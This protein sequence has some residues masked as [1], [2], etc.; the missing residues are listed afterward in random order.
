MP[1]MT[2]KILKSVDLT[3]TQNLDL[4]NKTLFFLHIKKIHSLHIKDY[5]NPKK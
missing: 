2:S 1:M 5:F 4:E 3:K